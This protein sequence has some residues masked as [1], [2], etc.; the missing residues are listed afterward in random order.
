MDSDKISVNG[1]VPFFLKEGFY[2]LIPEGT[3]YA[4]VIPVKRKLWKMIHSPENVDIVI[5]Q[6]A[7]IHGEKA[8]YKKKAWIRKEYN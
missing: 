8:Y 1:N 6:S 2:G 7:K 5:Q 3:P 4:Q